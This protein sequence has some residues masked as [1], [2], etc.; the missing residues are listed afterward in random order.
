MTGHGWGMPVRQIVGQE[1]T[2]MMHWIRWIPIIAGLAAAMP[3]PAAAQDAASRRGWTVTAAIGPARID[4]LAGTPLVPT[5]SFERTVGAR[6]MFGARLGW[7]GNAGF[8]SLN[9]LTLDLGL[10]L[11]AAGRRT[12]GSVM[13]GPSVIL[14]GDSDGTPYAAVGPQLTASGTVWV[15]DRIGLTAA[16]LMR[17][18]ANGDGMSLRPGLAAGITLRL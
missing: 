14:G 15:G 5:A 6:G 11:R 9:A 1:T 13:A 3:T 18:W 16:G 8:Y 12:E 7:I 2:N 4:R 17:A 10:G